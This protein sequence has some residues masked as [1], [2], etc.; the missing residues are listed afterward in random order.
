MTAAAEA[1]LRRIFAEVLG[2]DQVSAHDAFFDVGGDS[3][4][5][6]QVVAQ[7][8]EAG[9]SLRVRDVFDHQTAGALAAVAGDLP[10][11]AGARDD[12]APADLPLVSLAAGDLDDLEDFEDFEN[13]DDDLGDEQAADMDLGWE[14]IT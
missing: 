5:A 12:A 7:A 10:G 4:L 14:T 3:V 11:A 9:L 2:R 13:L 8:R 6:L 1:T